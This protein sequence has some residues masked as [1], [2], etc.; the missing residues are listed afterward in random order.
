[1]FLIDHQS[2]N[3][4]VPIRR[5]CY[6]RNPQR[7]TRVKVRVFDGTLWVFL[8]LSQVCFQSPKCVKVKK[9]HVPRL[10]HWTPFG[11]QTPRDAKT[12]I[13]TKWTT[14]VQLTVGANLDRR[15]LWQVVDSVIG[16]EIWCQSC[17]KSLNKLIYWYTHNYYFIISSISMCKMCKW[18][19]TFWKPS[20]LRPVDIIQRDLSGVPLYS[21]TLNVTKE[22]VW[23][24]H[25]QIFP[26]DCLHLPIL[27][28]QHDHE[29]CIDLILARSEASQHLL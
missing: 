8:R 18:S 25:H 4:C 12:R 28:I 14:S 17:G 26:N 27:P 1:M 13:D 2:I 22:H 11:S 19:S 15:V 7:S 29:E 24:G 23:E 5:F 16:W 10:K 20:I 21:F 9:T 3:P 6:N